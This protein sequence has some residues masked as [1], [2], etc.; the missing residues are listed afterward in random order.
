MRRRWYNHSYPGKP[1]METLMA[2]IRRQPRLMQLV[3]FGE[4]LAVPYWADLGEPTRVE[5]VRLLA[6]LLFS[7][8]GNSLRRTPQT[9]G[10][11]D[12]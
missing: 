1:V 8:H 9:R 7:I 5:V 6:Q 3:L 12:E 2:T 10:G 11:R 4:R